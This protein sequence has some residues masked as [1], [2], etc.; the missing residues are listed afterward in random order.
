MKKTALFIILALV[1]FKLYQPSFSSYFFQ[2]DW[3]SLRISQ[4]NTFADFG[5]MFLPRSDVIYYR[6]IGMQLPY[7]F[8]Q[9]FFGLNPLP[10]HILTFITHLVNILLVYFL[11]KL[12]T[13]KKFASLFAAFLYGTSLVHYTPFFWSATYAFVLGPTAF[14]LTYICFLIFLRKKKKKYLAFSLISFTLGLLTNEII[15][16]LPLIFLLQILIFEKNKKTLVYLT[17][18]ILLGLTLFLI[19]L[20]I[21]PP[22]LTGSYHIGF[23]KYL[24]NN[25]EGYLLWS[26]N[27]PEEIKAQLVNFHTINP[28]FLSEFPAYVRSFSFNSLTIILFLIILPTLLIIRQKKFRL[29]IYAI[30][31]IIW[32]LLSLAPVIFFSQHT[33]SYYLPVALIGLLLPAGLLLDSFLKS[34]PQKYS[35]ISLLIIVLVCSSWVFST[36]MGID[37]NDKIHWVPRRAKISKSL[38]EEA[39]K[40]YQ[41]PDDGYIIYVRPDSENKLSLNDQDAFKMVLRDNRI[42]TRYMN[43]AKRVG[44][45]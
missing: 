21:Y 38:I 18:Y 13:G 35:L 26:L 7:F 10:F 23:G 33:F 6:P 43:V 37:F 41:F 30:F 42:E 40:V 24:F 25:L 4:V 19:R 36:K 32:F 16:V 20:V 22:P 9:N 28:Q 27:W 2:D 39:L 15:I 1:V 31:G 29:F 34:I 12:L 11:V 45:L 3:F 8:L 17:P 44:I 5:K 14:F